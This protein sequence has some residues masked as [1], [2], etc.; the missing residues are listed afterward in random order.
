VR[1]LGVVEL[2]GSGQG[3]E[4]SLRDPSQAAALQPRVV[5]D[6]DA[7]EEGDLFPA[8]ASDAAAAAELG[9]A[10]LV[11]RESGAAGDEEFADLGA[12][13]HDLHARASLSCDTSR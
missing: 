1:A 9:Q 4:H 12:V 13:V 2:Q 11:R 5:L 7:G 6:A 3:F 8:E 10:H